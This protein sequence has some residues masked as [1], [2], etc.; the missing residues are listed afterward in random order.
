MI[1]KQDDT[2]MVS[3]S[4]QN[5]ITVYEWSVKTIFDRSIKLECLH[6][7]YLQFTH[8]TNVSLAKSAFSNYK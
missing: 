6:V 2:P 8:N 3:I 5:A 1:R 4:I 7:L